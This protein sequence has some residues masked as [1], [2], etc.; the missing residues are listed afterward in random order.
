M[1]NKLS[2]FVSFLLLVANSF[3]QTIVS[4]SP[5]NQ[6]VIFEEFTGIHCT[7]CPSGHTISQALQDA[8][9][10]RVSLIYI[11]QGGYANP[12]NGEPDFRTQWGNAIVNQTYSG[13]GF[14]YPSATVNRHIFPGRSMASGGGTA[15]AR[16][17]WVISA[18]ETMAKVSPVNL[19]VE[20]SIDVQTNVMTVHVEGY[21]I[22]DSPETTNL[23]NV[24]LLQ[25][26]TK[27]PQTGGGA[28]NNYI[29]MH[30]L[31]EMITGQWGELINNTTANTFV[32]RT[33]TY[34]IPT[35]YN[36][37]PTVLE[38]M[39]VVAYISNTNQE[40]PTGHSTLPTFTG[41]TI[42]YDASLLEIPEILPTCVDEF[43]TD[44]IV[45][46]VGI[47]P[48][49]SIA[50]QYIVNG[51]SHTYN[52]VG[53]ILSLR[54]EAISLP[55]VNYTLNIENTLEVALPAD[56]NNSNNSIS[57][58]FEKAP[59]GTGLVNLELITDNWGY[60]MS[61]KI[62]DSNGDIVDSGDSPYSNSTINIDLSLE[63]D[64]YSIILTDSGN[65][66]GTTVTLTD[67]QG[68]QLFFAEGNWGSKR[69]GNFRSNGVLEINSFNTDKINLYPNPATTILNL[70]N[71]ENA[72]ILI[73]D[74]LGKL[75]IS[76]KNVAMD[77][78]INVSKLRDGTYF[79]KISKDNL[80][81]TKRFLISK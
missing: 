35:A 6:N 13:S 57:T 26:N 22:S 59:Q 54:T 49:T 45:K 8:N 65:N 38:D 63:A 27:G 48:L 20:A 4:T 16:P 12:G 71:A 68:T 74:V 32:D 5:Q 41:L 80:T 66:G 64:C 37:V 55:P 56:D 61:W 34:T 30:R 3:S 47:E 15:M 23:L 19:A 67:S 75:I 70:R 11:H 33:F 78:L 28:G 72:N 46:N 44:I 36:D 77:S 81:T 76:Q 53:N 2:L 10:D 62:L 73:Y 69:K 79:M 7:F 31:V 25:N 9:P 1:I 40:I 42:A 21:Y 51:D 17:Y 18:N 58:T 50:I 14:G 39:E 29:H 60:Q 24:A 43:G 52:W